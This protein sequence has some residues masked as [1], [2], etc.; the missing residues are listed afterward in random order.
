MSSNVDQTDTYLGLFFHIVTD[1]WFKSYFHRILEVLINGTG[2]GVDGITI[3]FRSDW[4]DDEH[5]ESS[6]FEADQVLVSAFWPLYGE[7]NDSPLYELVSYQEFCDRFDAYLETYY[8]PEHPGDIAKTK[9]LMA[10]LRENLGVAN[11]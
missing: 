1:Q 4:D 9:E 8:Y 10:K 6:M 5:P 11:P 7:L 2:V 3:T